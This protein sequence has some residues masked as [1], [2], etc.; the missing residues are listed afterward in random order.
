MSIVKLLSKA[1]T[2]PRIVVEIPPARPR[3]QQVKKP[4]PAAA[5]APKASKR[6]AEDSIDPEDNKKARL[7]LK[8]VEAATK[9]IVP[10]IDN[11]MAEMAF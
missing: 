7:S 6:Q 1:E 5:P 11:I 3:I 8:E 10:E 2:S 9:N 4:S